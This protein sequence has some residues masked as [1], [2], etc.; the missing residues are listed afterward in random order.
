MNKINNPN[1]GRSWCQMCFLD[2]QKQPNEQEFIIEVKQLKE[3]IELGKYSDK[4]SGSVPSALR[5]EV[6][7]KYLSDIYRRGKCFCCRTTEIEESNFECGHVI[8]KKNGGPITLDNLRPVCGQ[9]NKSMG[10]ISMD[11]FIV[12]CGFW[13]IKKEPVIEK[14]EPYTVHQLHIICDLL[15]IDFNTS[16]KTISNLIEKLTD[17]GVSHNNI[18]SKIEASRNYKFIVRCCNTKEEGSHH[19]FTNKLLFDA[20]SNDSIGR[21]YIE[22]QCCKACKHKCQAYAFVNIFYK[23]M[24]LLRKELRKE[25]IIY[26]RK[27]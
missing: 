20:D 14:K 8:S 11:D 2:Q 21:Y 4:I 5:H 15:D 26:S 9:C 1:P 19:Y 24:K 27:V 25:G 18:L 23:D 16:N 7:K 22:K 6:W 17:E 10:A 3:N 12:A 13:T